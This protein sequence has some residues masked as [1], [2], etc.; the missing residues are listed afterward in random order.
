MAPRV[1]SFR[2][3]SLG[4]DQDSN[5]QERSQNCEEWRVALATG[6]ATDQ[7]TFDS[8]K[9]DT[10][11]AV[12][13]DILRATIQNGIR[14]IFIMNGHDG[15]IAAIEVAAREIKMECPEARIVALNDWWIAAGK[16]L[17]PNTFEVWDGL[18]HAGE[19]ETSIALNMFEDWCEMDRA[20]GVVPDRIPPHVDVKWDFAELT[21]TAATG[22]PTRATKEKG[23]KMEKVLMDLVVGT[24][25]S[26]DAC[27]WSY[28]STASLKKP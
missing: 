15:N 13:K 3:R 23:E 9:Y 8:L 12:I 10:M 1:R 18:G 5:D 6:W 14:K 19:G 2:L 4:S 20:A 21:D 24:L 27:D 22:D 16:L 11:I 17:P 7:P 25:K 28:A 26:L